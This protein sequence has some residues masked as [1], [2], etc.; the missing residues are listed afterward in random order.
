M[1]SDLINWFDLSHCIVGGTSKLGTFKLLL[2]SYPQFKI[3]LI[4]SHILCLDYSF[5]SLHSS[6]FLPHNLPPSQDP[7][8]LR[9][10]QIPQDVKQTLHNKLQENSAQPL[11]SRLDK[12]D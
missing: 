7:F 2:S 11:I 3:Y 5:L 4:F 12:A 10:E 9:K 1:K 6:Q 8:L